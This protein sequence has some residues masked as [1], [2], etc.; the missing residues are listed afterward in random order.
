ML[1]NKLKC[2]KKYM[3]KEKHLLFREFTVADLEYLNINLI[4][5]IA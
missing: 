1:L 2:H 3:Y 4:F 5:I